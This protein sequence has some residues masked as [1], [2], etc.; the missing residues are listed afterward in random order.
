MNC[1]QLHLTNSDERNKPMTET[2]LQLPQKSAMKQS[3]CLRAHNRLVNRRG[4]FGD[5]AKNMKTVDI[6]ARLLAFPRGTPPV[7]SFK[8]VEVR[9]YQMQKSHE[10][11]KDLEP[12]TVDEFEASGRTLTNKMPYRNL[13][14]TNSTRTHVLRMAGLTEQEIEDAIK[15]VERMKVKNAIVMERANRELMNK[16]NPMNFFRGKINSSENLRVL[17]IKEGPPS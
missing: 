11:Y 15:R 9:L 4:S 17:T 13:P 14:I 7:V 5:F 8:S 3:S 2:D 10:I 6:L 12:V 16:S 1:L